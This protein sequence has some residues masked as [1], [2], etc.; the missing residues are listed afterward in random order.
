MSPATT[1]P[2]SRIRSRTSTSPCERVGA[3]G[4]N[5]AKTLWENG[6][7]EELAQGAK[8]NVEIVFRNPENVADFPHFLLQP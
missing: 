3:T 4:E 8:I 7:S 1:S 2:L 6:V 5:S